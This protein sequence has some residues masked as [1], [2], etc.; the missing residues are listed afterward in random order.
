MRV[1]TAL[2]LLLI[3]VVTVAA[4]CTTSGV[5][6]RSAQPTTGHTTV[7]EAT[8]GGDALG[9][10]GCRPASP[11]TVFNRFLAE[12][13]GTGH[14]ATLWGLLMFPHPLPAQ[15]G[16]QEKIVWRMTGTVWPLSL[17][18]IGP[19][20]TRHPLLWG[21]SAHQAGSNWPGKYKPGDEW[22]AGYVFTAP[23][24]WDLRA[25][26]GRATADV[27]LTVIARSQQV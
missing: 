11:V 1:R 15:V 3:S 13:E 17:A 10:P 19:D 16:D 4:A 23:G 18:A 8:P 22:G 12:V 27:W 21:P 7:P 9:S 2:A 24:C 25:V 6:P 5:A 14:G 20:G 26:R